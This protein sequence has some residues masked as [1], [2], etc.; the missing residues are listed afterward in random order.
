MVPILK[1]TIPDFIFL[2]P[3]CLN[4]S[5]PNKPFKITIRIQH[6]QNVNKLYIWILSFNHNSF[7]FH[8]L[9]FNV[10]VH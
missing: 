8:E 7:A 4:S 6:R 9:C 3:V 2:S 1:V 10:G 5:K